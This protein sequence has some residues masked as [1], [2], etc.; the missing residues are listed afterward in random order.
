MPK[1]KYTKEELNDMNS[2]LKKLHIL[3]VYFRP[4]RLKVNFKLLIGNNG[5]TDT[6]RAFSAIVLR[7][8]LWYQC[9]ISVWLLMEFLKVTEALKQEALFFS[10]V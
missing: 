5:V 7:Q 6:E 1:E 8:S 4:L 10:K 3:T 2:A 9:M